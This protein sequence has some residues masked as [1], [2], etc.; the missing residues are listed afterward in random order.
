MRGPFRAVFL[1][2]EKAFEA[3]FTIFYHICNGALKITTKLGQDVHI[4]FGCE[5]IMEPS[6]YNFVLYV[7]RSCE[8]MPVYAMFFLCVPHFQ[9]Y[10]AIVL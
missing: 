10:T 9:M 6:G 7:D 1:S 5:I 2:E 3:Q 8:N 4:Q